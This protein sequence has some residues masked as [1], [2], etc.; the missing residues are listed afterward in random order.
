[1]TKPDAPTWLGEIVERFCVEGGPGVAIGVARGEEILCRQGFGLA[2]LEIPAPMTPATLVPIASI[3]K[4]MTALCALRLQQ[5]GLLR[6]DAPIGEYLPH[7]PANVKKPT[8][9]QLLSHLSGLRCHLDVELFSGFTAPRP[10]GFGMET[11][12][13]L[14]SVNAPPGAWQV[15]G[16]SGFHLVSRAIE[17]VTG[18]S[19]ADVMHER[20]FAPL[21]MK[22]ARVAQSAA[23]VTPGLASLY[24]RTSEG[25][26]S[27]QSHMRVES[28]GEGGVCAS[29]NDMMIWARALRTE[30]PRI[31]KT[32]W[33]KL[34]TPVQLADGSIS[35]YALGLGVSTRRG[36]EI[37]G[38]SGMIIGQ[39]STLLCA[40]AFDLDIVVLANTTIAVDAIARELLEHA[41]GAGAFEP[42]PSPA[43]AD[44]Y[45]GL[46]G[47]VFEAH[48]LWVGFGAS[49][50]KLSLS[51]QGVE[52]A[53]LQI[54]AASGGLVL[55]TNLGP[56]HLLLPD[57]A[58]STIFDLTFGGEKHRLVA[59]EP[60]SAKEGAN[61]L[62]LA[63]GSYA[64]D[65]LNSTIT[66]TRLERE[67]Y[68]VDAHGPHGAYA[69]E[70]TALTRRVLKVKTPHLGYLLRL[71][72][73]G[74]QVTSIGFD[75][76][77]TRNLRFNRQ[78]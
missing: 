5:D 33:R 24:S 13:R 62:S 77:R 21:G 30:D 8:L 63:A 32:I 31:D 52:G 37:I 70:A 39:S 10:D 54:D 49:E 78:P 76:L 26:W 9:I 69:G 45:A 18:A 36:V 6:L 3:T 75:T 40:P 59:Q 15:Y 17:R 72:H 34:K 38:H 55:A 48:D 53:P 29:L 66:I 41:I 43:Q 20:L 64:C 58:R 51:L 28:L 2:H 19:F 14:S 60:L 56:M 35:E 67:L 73:S 65:E 44:D 1:M 74:D 22:G 42:A 16:N 23:S 4:Q 71:H 12:Q 61:V 46:I 57:G 27:N 11:L 7:L 47:R 25:G 68:R 50:G